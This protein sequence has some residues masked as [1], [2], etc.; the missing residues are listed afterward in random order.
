MSE[1]YDKYLKSMPII[2]D[3]ATKILSIAEDK[4][5]I[6]FKDLEDII[7]VDP[8]LTAKV[9]KIAN[10]AMYARQREI[11]SLQMAITLLG[12][13]N[14]KSLVLLVTASGSFA[15]SQ[16]DPFYQYFWKHGIL[17]AFLA[18]HM[19]I[20]CNR[21]D[22]SEDCFIAGLLHDIGQVAFYNADKERYQ[23][24]VTALIE[25]KTPVEGIENKIYA[26]DHRQIGASLLKR[27]SFPDF[28]VDAA[29][30][31]QSLNITSPHKASIFIVSTADLVSELVR[32]GSLEADSEH[33]L[34][35][36]IERVELTDS[37]FQYYKTSFM[38]DMQKDPLFLECRSL[39][40]I[41]D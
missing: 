20:R 15:R 28:Y 5:D 39:F 22:A 27:W 2:P 38:T 34:G 6:S 37:D 21:K 26:N 3:V 29:R 1:D 7:K 9:L 41:R 14:L 18:R 25:G 24:V 19:A 36:L 4:L 8:S 32:T 16:Q 30:E 12:F 40:G 33:L 17:T 10:S 35:E 11:K 13:K 31:H 23:P